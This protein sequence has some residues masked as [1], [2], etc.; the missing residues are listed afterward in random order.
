MTVGWAATGFMHACRKDT[1][2]V[3]R[4]R[5]QQ[6]EKYDGDDLVTL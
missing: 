2:Q 5:K 1:G 6:D 4:E 3:P